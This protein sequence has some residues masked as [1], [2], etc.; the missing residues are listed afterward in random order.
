MQK[1]GYK[2]VDRA[3]WVKR[4]G[5]LGSVKTFFDE[6]GSNDTYG[7][8]NGMNLLRKETRTLMGE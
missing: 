1:L 2:I 4:L 5:S 7:F 3:G 8:L 6:Q